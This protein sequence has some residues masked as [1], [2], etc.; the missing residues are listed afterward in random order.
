MK[1]DVNFIFFGIMILLVLCMV[2]IAL[3]SDYSYHDVNRRYLE[4]RNKLEETQMELNNTRMQL[5]EREK[6]LNQTERQL[7]D[8]INELNLSK[9]RISSLGEYYTDLK[10]EKE[11]LEE[12]LSRVIQDRD[13]WKSNY[14][15]AQ[16]NIAFCNQSL[17]QCNL[18][19]GFERSRVDSLRLKMAEFSSKLDI[20]RGYL[21]SLR[22]NSIQLGDANVSEILI[23]DIEVMDTFI[24]DLQ[25]NVTESL[26]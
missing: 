10:G 24:E 18:N 2:G 22:D 6:K 12:N 15:D 9:Q 23:P 7:V 5:E 26:S 21:D 19:L 20:L 13:A 1:R 11:E 25:A 16:Q 3:Y 8:I 14:F 17:K 4:F